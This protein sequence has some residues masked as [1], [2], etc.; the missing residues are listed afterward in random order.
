MIGWIV[1]VLTGIWTLAAGIQ[2]VRQTF[3]YSSGKAAAT[4]IL[5]WLAY[6][7]VLFL[8]YIWLPSPYKF[9]IP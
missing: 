9:K 2:A 5:G 4:C 7:A 6:M 1:I 8:V 3:D